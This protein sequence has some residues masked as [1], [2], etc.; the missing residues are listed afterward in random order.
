MS[1]TWEN[2]FL[3]LDS[4]EIG[5]NHLKAFQNATLSL[6]VP[7]DSFKESLLCSFS[8][9]PNSVIMLA[10]AFTGKVKLYHSCKNLGGT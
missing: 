1:N 10:L 2:Y 8:E 6:S 3:N 7:S 4:N 9:D 5:N